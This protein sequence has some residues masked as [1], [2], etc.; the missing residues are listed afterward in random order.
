MI[1]YKDILQRLKDAGYN[2]G[3]IMRNKLLSQATV[4][5][6]RH[7][8]PINTTS[9]NVICKLAQCQPGDI[10]EYVEDPAEDSINE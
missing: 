9:I 6:I 2:T 4:D 5:A 3:V 10:M 8:R 7:N 1:V